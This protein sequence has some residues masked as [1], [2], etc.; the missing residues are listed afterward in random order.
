MLFCMCG[1]GWH[2]AYI[3][4]G[5]GCLAVHTVW[6]GVRGTAHPLGNG[7]PGGTYPARN[8]ECCQLLFGRKH[9]P[10]DGFILA[11]GYEA[12]WEQPDCSCKSSF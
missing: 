2:A 5:M 10:M 1:V 12:H 8:A 4:R 7:M 3:A 6:N 9:A 11:V